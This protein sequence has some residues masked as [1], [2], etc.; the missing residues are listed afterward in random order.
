MNRRWWIGDWLAFGER[1]YGETYS[2]AVEATGH[3]ALLLEPIFT[4]R[5]K[6][7]QSLSEGRGKKGLENSTNLNGSDAAP[8]KDSFREAVNTRREI[9][10]IAGVSDNTIHRVNGATEK[11]L[12]SRLSSAG[13]SQLHR[14]WTPTGW[15]IS[16]TSTPNGSHNQGTGA[17]LLLRRNRY[18]LAVRA[19]GS[20]RLTLRAHV[21]I[22]NSGG[23]VTAFPSTVTTNQT[24]K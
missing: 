9:A 16:R 7:N 2:Q 21:G 3:V 18:Q 17:S 19:E 14:C 15:P 4:Q 5:A 8:I 11:T 6:K 24:D 1:V 23:I 10:K 12:R 13:G 20:A 22:S